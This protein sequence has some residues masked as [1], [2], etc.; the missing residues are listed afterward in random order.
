MSVFLPF[1][2]VS[3]TG[4]ICRWC[5]WQYSEMHRL[6]PGYL[7]TLCKGTLQ[8]SHCLGLQSNGRALR[9]FL[10]CTPGCGAA[11]SDP[12]GH[13]RSACLA[14][15]ASPLPLLR[16]GWIYFLCFY[17]ADLC[18]LSFKSPARDSLKL[19]YIEIITAGLKESKIWRT[20]YSVNSSWCYWEK[21]WKDDLMNYSRDKVVTWVQQGKQE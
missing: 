19:A 2:K 21:G 18:A 9:E 5:S 16:Q 3:K 20:P 8:G 4:H 11:A 12:S 17:S 15:T 1:P 10:H 7:R 13:T 14:G 6:D